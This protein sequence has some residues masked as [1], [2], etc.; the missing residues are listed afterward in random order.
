ME[1]SSSPPYALT[2]LDRVLYT[3]LALFPSASSGNQASVVWYSGDGDLIL[4]RLLPWTLGV[5]LALR[6]CLPILRPLRATLCLRFDVEGPALL[7]G[8]AEEF[9]PDIGRD[10]CLG[11]FSTSVMEAWHLVP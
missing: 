9:V 5:A 8:W 2:Y 6:P 3:T 10:V 1:S 7:T 4:L 11:R